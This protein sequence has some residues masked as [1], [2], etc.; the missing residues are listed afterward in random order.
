MDQAT[1]RCILVLGMH[2]SGTSAFARLVSLAGAALPASVVGAHAGNET[3]HWEPRAVQLLNDRTLAKLD[4]SW[5]DWRRFDWAKAGDMAACNYEFEFT[6]IVASQYGN[7][8]LFVLKEP[9][10]CRFADRAVHALGK[11]GIDVRIVITVRNPLEVCGSLSKRNAL[12]W[13]DA[14][15][16]WLRYTLEAERATRS[17]ARSIVFY[18]RL[19]EDWR[20]E[21]ARLSR[22]LDVIWPRP[23]VAFASEV[24]GFIDTDQ[25][26]H[27]ADTAELGADELTAGWMLVAY[28]ALER[29]AVDPACYKAIRNLDRVGREFDNAAP[30]LEE[31]YQRIPEAE[32]GLRALNKPKKPPRTVTERLSAEM[33]RWHRRARWAK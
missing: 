33:R 28:R 4:R 24:N 14:A 32:R 13:V 21:F 27:A 3:G 30:F 20:G 18:D 6:E 9:R 12:P 19:L 22:Q 7:E 25:R 29:L 31:L 1:R 11:G 15:L 2:R 10:L 5:C 26:H 16:L 8:N 17:V 23:S